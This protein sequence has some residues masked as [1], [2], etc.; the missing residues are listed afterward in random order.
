MHTQCPAEPTV[1][2]AE[3]TVCPAEPTV[4][5]PEQ[6]QETIFPQEP[7]RC[8]VIITECPPYET[9]CTDVETQCPYEQTICPPP[10]T[11]I[12]DEL[13]IPPWDDPTGPDIGV[14]TRY[15][16]VMSECPA[17]DVQ[18]PTVVPQL[19]LAKAP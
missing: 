19:L 11:G 4:C 15:S 8:P 7:T 13:P 14:G 6:C 18:C 5:P 17:I 3:P 1:C 2:P 9:W 16:S 10:K 12:C